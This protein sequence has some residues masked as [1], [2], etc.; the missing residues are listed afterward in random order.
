MF[1]LIIATRNAHKVQ[2]IQA[3]LGDGFNCLSLDGFDGVPTPVEDGGHFGD[4]A[5]IKAQV[6]ARWLAENHANRFPDPDT[7]VLADDSGLEVDALEGAPGV[8]SARYAA[9]DTGAEGNSSDAD[10]NAKLLRLLDG[11][12]AGK[13][14]ARFRCSLVLIS[15]LH[16]KENDAVIAN[17]TCEGRITDQGGGEGGFGYDPLFI[18]DGYD[19]SFAELGE[20]IKNGLSHRARAVERL[21]PFFNERLRQR[22]KAVEIRAEPRT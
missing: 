1:T 7:F 12:P 22:Q 4:N 17:G 16:Q 2:E 14:S 13:R 6:I 15:L 3:L 5:N 20:E 11:V 19:R 18:P 10:N 8:H 9:L 21:K